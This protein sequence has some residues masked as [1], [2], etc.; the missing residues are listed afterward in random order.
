[1]AAP[2]SER[3]EARIDVT[4]QPRARRNEIVGLNEGIVVARVCAPPVDEEANHALCRMIAKRAGVAPS[5]VRVVAGAHG[6]HK[7]LHVEGL[8]R[9]ALI[10]ALG[11]SEG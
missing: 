4:L 11:F 9:A 8:D 1:M 3:A 6:R 10:E 7:Q 5:R 2:V